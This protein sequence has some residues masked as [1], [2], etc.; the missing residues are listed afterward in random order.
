MTD[1]SV[2]RSLRVTYGRLEFYTSLD[3]KETWKRLVSVSKTRTALQHLLLEASLLIPPLYLGRTNCVKRR[4][5]EHVRDSNG[6]FHHRF[7]RHTAALGIALPVSD[8]FF[9]CLR[10][11]SP[12]AKTSVA[13]TTTH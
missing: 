6:N 11:E 2:F 9:A 13:S 12:S 1:L 3:A 5:S 4:Y 10:T 7:T 8:L